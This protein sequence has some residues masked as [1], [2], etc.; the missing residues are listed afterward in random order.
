MNRRSIIKAR[1]RSGSGRTIRLSGR[2]SPGRHGQNRRGRAA[3]RRHG[4]RRRGHPLSELQALGARGQRQ[5]R[6]QAQERPEE[7]R[8]DRVRRS[9]PARRNHQ[10][11]RAARGRTRSDFIMPVYGT[12]FNLA[13]A[14]IFAK[15]GYPQ[16]TQ[17]AVTDQIDTLTQ[18]YPTLFFVQGSTT[19]FA[20]RRRQR[21]EE[22]E[23]RRQDRQ[24]G[25]DRQRR[26]RVRHR[27]RQRR[28]ADLPAGR[29]RHR[30]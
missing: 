27:A 28:P 16:V 23:G 21:A 24:Q 1:R 26:R 25:R 9:Q 5:R 4:E 30:L 14:P 3:H 29:L 18:R 20:S 13:A 10:G 2:Q 15:Y 22:A 12:G 7:G 8:A 19:S 11:G 6:A 17:A